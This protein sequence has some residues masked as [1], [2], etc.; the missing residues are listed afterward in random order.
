MQRLGCSS[1][2]ARTVAPTQSQGRR[3]SQTKRSS[4]RHRPSLEAAGILA[5]GHPGAGLGTAR[6]D[7][8]DL[9]ARDLFNE[10]VGQRVARQRPHPDAHA[11][12]ILLERRGLIAA[13]RAP[14]AQLPEAVDARGV[15]GSRHAQGKK[16]PEPVANDGVY[17]G[18]R[19]DDTVRGLV[20]RANEGC[21]RVPRL[22][23]WRRRTDHWMRHELEHRDSGDQH[24]DP[25][26]KAQVSPCFSHAGPMLAG[27]RSL[28]SFAEEREGP[29][30]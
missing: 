13:A 14:D 7:E 24:P 25:G 16:I 4:W 5:R 11:V 8:L 28:R 1:R 29:A 3:R 18:W 6:V 15:R 26:S 12:E 22:V 21:G 20:P 9:C 19:P 17:P 23:A 27:L 10:V 30:L 2:S